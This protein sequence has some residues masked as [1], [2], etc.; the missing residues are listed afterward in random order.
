MSD[1]RKPFEVC[2]CHSTHYA[3][4]VQAAAMTPR[5]RTLYAFVGESQQPYQSPSKDLDR[6]NGHLSGRLPHVVGVQVSDQFV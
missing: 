3:V 2:F 6:I 1:T 5:T 4:C